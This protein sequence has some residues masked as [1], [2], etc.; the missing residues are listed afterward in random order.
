MESLYFY[1][2]SLIS[3]IQITRG[4]ERIG[5]VKKRANK[6]VSLWNRLA[7]GLERHIILFQY[8]IQITVK[9]PLSHTSL[10]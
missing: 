7:I 2:K 8:E 4:N 3:R 5:K 9:Q 6:V 1:L 10:D